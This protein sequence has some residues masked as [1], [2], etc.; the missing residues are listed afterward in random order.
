MTFTTYRD[1]SGLA[2]E[3]Y[4]RYFV[5]TIATAASN[6]LL[7]AAGLRRGERVL[8]VACG[9]GLIARLA[10]EQ[11]GTSGSVTGIDLAP[12]MIDVARAQPT[13]PGAAI[14][15]HV[16][17]ATT[18]PLPETSYDVVL[19]QLALMFIGD[20][21]AAAREMHRVLV[22]GGRAVV[23][24]PGPPHRLFQLLEE[25]IA[26]HVDPELATFVGAVFSL[27]DP[28]MV[29]DLLRAAGFT[30]VTATVQDRPLRLPPPA[31]FLWQ[32]ISL[33]PIAASVAQAPETDRAALERWVVERW[34]PFEVDGGL[35]INQAIVVASGS[36]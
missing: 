35:R 12:D 24:T 1:F 19:C 2:A 16:A 9:T 28:D 31:D 8:D 34:Q 7:G 27:P 20:R 6:D 3:N 17:D 14:D 4:Q 15:W 18:L 21:P 32:Y 23:S 29:A 11:V 33:T 22:P 25:A 36:A 13:P 30:G 5:P 10:A 26:D